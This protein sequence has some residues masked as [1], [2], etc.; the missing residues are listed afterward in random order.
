MWRRARTRGVFLA[1]S[2]GICLLATSCG[3]R[4]PGDPFPEIALGLTD[5]KADMVSTSCPPVRV[6]RVTLVRPDPSHVIADDE[7][8]VWQ[9]NFTS[10]TSLTALVVGDVPDGGTEVVSLAAPST[11]R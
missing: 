5:G 7:P 2:A 11:A 9:V 4:V 8:V 10:P 6:S 1:T 3:T